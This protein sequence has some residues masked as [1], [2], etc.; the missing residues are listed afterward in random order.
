[1]DI[2]KQI[3][4]DRLMEYKINNTYK[5]SETQ[6]ISVDANDFNFLIIYGKHINGWFIA[7]PN[8]GICTE[9]S[10][11]SSGF[12]YNTEKLAAVEDIN[13]KNASAIIAKAIK[14]HWE[15]LQK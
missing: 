9:A 15:G 8:H 14:E 7:I 2:K 6:E 5:V 13:V 3:R 1:M 12:A 11:P 10:H 4:R